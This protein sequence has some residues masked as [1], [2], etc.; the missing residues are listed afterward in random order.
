MLATDNFAS[1]YCISSHK[2]DMLYEAD[3]N[4]AD[5]NSFFTTEG[6]NVGENIKVCGPVTIKRNISKNYEQVAKEFIAEVKMFGGRKHPNIL[7]LFGFCLEGYEMILIF[8]S[9]ALYKSLADHLG[10]ISEKTNLMQRIRICIDIAQGLDYFHENMDADGTVKIH[11]GML[12]T[13]VLL[14]EK[15]NAKIATFRL[16]PEYIKPPRET[17]IYSFGVV[18]FEILCGRLAYD[19]Y[20]TRENSMEL[21]R[22]TQSCFEE[23]TFQSMVDPNIMEEVREDSYMIAPFRRSLNALKRIAY[24][25]LFEYSIILPLTLKH[26]IN[27]LNRALRFQ[28]AT[29][30]LI[31]KLT[32][33]KSLF[34]NILATAIV[35]GE[36]SEPIRSIKVMSELEGKNKDGSG[37]RGSK[38]RNISGALKKTHC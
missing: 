21:V 17:E 8:E 7:S 30:N 20:N 27:S 26:I 33:K 13:N 22:I 18:I 32:D 23:G 2:D 10:S 15:W 38:K 14:D 25:C 11:Q 6:K 9:C 24:R 4:H 28:E 5:V 36:T 29:M 35:E 37:D 1:R 31:K 16:Y 34:Q 3:V 12:S 19:P